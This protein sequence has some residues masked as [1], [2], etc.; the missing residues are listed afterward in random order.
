M[1]QM[2]SYHKIIACAAMLGSLT[3]A[4]NNVHAGAG[5]GGGGGLPNVCT[6]T[7]TAL[8]QSSGSSTK[9]SVLTV[10]A[11]TKYTL[12][13]KHLLGILAEDYYGNPNTPFPDVAKLVGVGGSGNGVTFQVWSVSKS[14]TTVFDV[15]SIIT[16]DQGGNYGSDVYSG[17]SNN[18]GQASPTTTDQQIFTLLFDDTGAP[19]NGH[20]QFYMSGVMTSTTTDGTPSAAGVYKET[21]SN[22][23]TSMTGDG[24]YDGAPLIITG[25][26]NAT[27]SGTLTT[28]T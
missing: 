18:S 21:Q 9:G 8:V 3:V 16:A 23:G 22:K 27:A 20:L 11:P 1:N 4:T 12:D 19:Y 2:N 10:N 14:G 7:A 15:S 26:L 24:N 17:K 13:T 28:G 5:G 6:I 25:G